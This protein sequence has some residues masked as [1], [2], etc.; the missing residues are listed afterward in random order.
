MLNG[1]SIYYV[2]F[3]SHL[4]AQLAV[5]VS[6]LASYGRHSCGLRQTCAK[7]RWRQALSANLEGWAKLAD[8]RIR[9]SSKFTAVVQDAADK[10]ALTSATW[11]PHSFIYN[12][13]LR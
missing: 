10:S 3:L 9:V 11:W 5:G 4:A 2:T 7:E 8:K 12:I 13:S 6:R 1:R